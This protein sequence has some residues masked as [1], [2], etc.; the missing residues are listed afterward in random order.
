MV[1]KTNMADFLKVKTIESDEDFMESTD[2]EE[3][4]DQNIKK[5][6]KKQKKKKDDFNGD[7]NLDFGTGNEKSLWRIAENIKNRAKGSISSEIVEEKIKEKRKIKLKEKKRELEKKEK[8]KIKKEEGEEEVAEKSDIDEEELDNELEEPDLSDY[9][10]EEDQDDEDE[11]DEEETGSFFSTAPKHLKHNNF[12]QMN[13]SR[14]LLRAINELNFV[15]PTEIQSTAIPMALLG[16]D[17]CA[18]ATTGSGK[19]AAFMLPILE[20]LIFKPKKTIVSRVLV[21]V[22]TR[23]LAIQVHSVSQSLAKYT[24]VTFC[25]AAGGLDLKVQVAV[26]RRNPDIIIAT[27]G[28]L[29]DHL[30][31]TP[32]FDLQTIEILVLDEA[33]RMLEEHFKDQMQELIRLCPRGRQTMLFSATMTEEVQ[34]L[35][36][37]SLNQPIKLFVNQNTDVAKSLHQEFMRIRTNREYDRLSIV[38]ALCC[39]SFHDHTLVFLQ[40]KRLAHKL[41]IVLGLFG[42]KVGELHGDL[43]QLQRLESLEKFKNNDV[44]ILVATDLA[45]RGLDI[46]HVKTVISFNLPTTIKSYIHRVGR[47]ARAGKA[48][49]SITLVG[50][51]ERKMLKDIVKN[52]NIPVKNRLMSPDVIAKYKKK[53]EEMEK[54]IK[55][56]LKQEE[57][58]KQIRIGEMQANKARNLVIHNDEIMSRP[59]RTFIKQ[60]KIDNKKG[61]H[62]KKPKVEFTEEEKKCRKFQEFQAR[63]MK[64]D[65][66]PKRKRAYEEDDHDNSRSKGK[67]SKKARI[68]ASGSSFDHD[69]TDVSRRKLKSL[70]SNQTQQPKKKMKNNSKTR[71]KKR[72]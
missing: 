36:S 24:D 55:D 2:E 1:F 14:P 8:V 4:K 61:D 54:D 26:L 72:K 9:E 66:K 40:T 59:A 34:E 70:R 50:E 65:K 32:S 41:R 7:F 33:D 12:N 20:R 56:I 13:L 17:L 29:I 60:K 58:E 43:T 30:H 63:Q 48:G 67:G 51:K 37:L 45:A 53:L 46:P 38:A 11:D 6:G 39:R 5:K 64:R 44:D 42:L 71:H 3:E 22:P 16:K 10:D 31:N 49:R 25:L 27:P 68:V 69:L 28:R 35:I 47:T 23:E 15:N 21:L 62:N 19:T 18:C 57:E 52:S